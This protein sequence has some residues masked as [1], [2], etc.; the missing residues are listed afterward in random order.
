[1]QVNVSIY[2]STNKTTHVQANGSSSV[3]HTVVVP[4]TTTG[5]VTFQSTASPAVTYFVLPASTIAGSYLFDA[6]C[7]NGL[8]VVTS[9]SDVVIVNVNA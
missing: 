4:K 2:I 6:V 9:A 5:T 1:M 7:G 8:D 3:V